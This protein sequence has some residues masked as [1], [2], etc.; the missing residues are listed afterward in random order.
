MHVCLLS[1][2]NKSLNRDVFGITA[3][4]PVHDPLAVAAILTG[5]PDEITFYDWDD[6]RSQGTKHDERFNVTVV[7]EGTFEAAQE[8]KFETGRT[9]AK[10]VE[11]GQP[12]VRIPR[13]V[14][15]EKFWKV[16]EECTQRA[17]EANIAL[18]KK[19]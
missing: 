5:T 2:A 13:S 3:G 17:D 9:I 16:L 12:G 6:E 1:L 7:T 8:G 19:F 11:A 14:D 18:G 4:P 15:V 10:L